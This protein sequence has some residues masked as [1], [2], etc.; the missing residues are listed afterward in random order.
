M[1]CLDLLSI[2]KKRGNIYIIKKPLG[3]KIPSRPSFQED[4][5]EKK[6]MKSE[7]AF[8]RRRQQQTRSALFGPLGKTLLKDF[9][10]GVTRWPVPA[11]VDQQ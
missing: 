5:R 1:K 6:K 9:A 3:M 10:T 2:K 8:H 11:G 7:S 4:L